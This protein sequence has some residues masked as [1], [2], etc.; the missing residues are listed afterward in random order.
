MRFETL[1]GECYN[2]VLGNEV[3]MGVRPPLKKKASKSS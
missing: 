2:L 1:T 3:L